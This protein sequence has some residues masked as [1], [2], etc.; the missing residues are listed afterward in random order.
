MVVL[1]QIGILKG[2][3][4]CHTVEIKRKVVSFYRDVKKNSEKDSQRRETL[5]YCGYAPIQTRSG[6]KPKEVTH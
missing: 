1:V 3:G 4:E 2:L 5:R 6:N